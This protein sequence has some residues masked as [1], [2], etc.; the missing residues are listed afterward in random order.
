MQLLILTDFVSVYGLNYFEKSMEA[1]AMLTQYR[2]ATAEFAV[3]PFIEKYKDKMLDEMKNWAKS[4]NVHIRRL[5]SEGCRISIPWGKKLEYIK[6]NPMKVIPILELLNSDSEEYV[7]KSVA[8]NINEISKISPH[9]VIDLVKSWHGKSKET[10][11]ILKDGCRTLIKKG[12]NEIMNL[13]G[14]N[15]HP[16]AKINMLSIESKSL[17]KGEDLIFSFNLTNDSGEQSKIII[18][19]EIIYPQLNGKAR[20][21]IYKLSER[22]CS[23]GTINIKRKQKLTDTSGLKISPGI[24]YIYILLNGTKMAND[25]FNVKE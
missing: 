23:E 21:K 8:N 7:R 18:S 14:L 13:L 15:T 4:D 3:R 6:N 19:Y 17:K 1:L 24:H 10:N 5:A 2:I 16:K 12:N 20:S 25:E 11:W 9:I 22:T